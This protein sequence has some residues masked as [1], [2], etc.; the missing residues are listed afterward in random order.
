MNLSHKCTH[1]CPF[2][3]QALHSKYRP[4]LCI[5]LYWLYTTVTN[6]LIGLQCMQSHTL[7]LL[8]SFLE[9]I[10]R[11]HTANA[12]ADCRLRRLATMSAVRLLSWA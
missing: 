1:A 6:M 4:M 3:E 7:T 8:A 5:L 12:V 11:R 10:R 2:T 9:T